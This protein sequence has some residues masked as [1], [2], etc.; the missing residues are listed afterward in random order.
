MDFALTSEQDML[1]DGA[2]RFVRERY[3]LEQRRAVIAGGGLDDANWAQFAEMGWLMLPFPEDVGGLGGAPEDVALLMIE[4]GRGLVAEPYVTS[5]LLCGT[6]LAGSANTAA[7]SA[8]EQIA[9]GEL[10]VALAHDE[11]AAPLAADATPALVAVR[12][13]DRLRLSGIKRTVLDAPAAHSLIVS[14]QLDGVCALILVPADAPGISPANYAL[15]DGAGAA[16]ISF[17]NVAVDG[18]ALI[19]TGDT[20]TTLLAQGIDAA[21]LGNLAQAVGSIEAILDICS[22]YLKTRQQ[23]GRPIGS[24][25]ALQHIMAQMFVEAQ[26]ARS[27][28]YFAIAATRADQPK[29]ERALAQAR[30]V[31]SEAA[32][33]VSRQG[34]QLHGG[35]GMTDEFSIGHH[36]KR[37]LTLEKMFGDAD[38]HLDALADM[39]AG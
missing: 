5:V 31:I 22:E 20:A 38:S 21:K 11:G 1:V 24:F 28:L 34:V 30:V 32:R 7:R 16:D 36:F 2:A 29:R 26:E 4:F 14:A 39:L 10:R 15:I 35:Y 25:Q 9:G 27:I 23:F 33:I 37:Q 18:D 3:G 13:G 6:I 8:A 19:A 17:E 12:E